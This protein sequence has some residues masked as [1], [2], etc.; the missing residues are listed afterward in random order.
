MGDKPELQ[1]YDFNS[2]DYDCVVLCF[3]VW[4]GTFAP[5]LRTF[6]EENRSALENKATGIIA[7]CS[8]GGADKAIGKLKKFLGTDEAAAELVLI[9]PKDKPDAANDKRIEDFCLK[10]SYER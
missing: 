9:D 1:H 4:A 2:G 5:P 7:C 10:L 8:G 3:P 6:V